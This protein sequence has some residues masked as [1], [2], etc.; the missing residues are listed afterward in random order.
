MAQSGTNYP[1]GQTAG[2]RATTAAQNEQMR[3]PPPIVSPQTV[4]TVVAGTTAVRGLGNASKLSSQEMFQLYANTNDFIVQLSS[5][6]SPM[7][8]FIQQ[9]AQISQLPMQ[10][11]R[12]WKQF[13]AA[14]S[15]SLGLVRRTGDA[16]LDAAAAQAASATAAIASVNAQA[17]ANVRAAETEIAL[18]TAQQQAAV[19]ANEQA[20]ASARLTAANE[21]LT[22]ANSQAAVS[23]RA[24]ATAQG[25]SS[26]ASNAATAA[27]TRNLTAM[28]RAGLVGIA[29]LAASAVAFGALTREANQGQNGLRRFTTEMGYTAKEVEELNS[30]SV[31]FGDTAKAVFVVGIERVASFFGFK[32]EDIASAWSRALNWMASTTRAVMAGI[33][34]AVAGMAYG[35]NNIVDNLGD[36]KSNDNPFANMVTGY[37]EAYG[38]AQAFFDDVV[39]SAQGAA[40]ARQD[41]MAS[42]MKS[43]GSKGK[44]GGRSGFDRAAE[45]AKANEELDTQIK[46]LAFYGDELERNQ[47]LEQI[48]QTFRQ[49]GAALSGAETKIIADKIQ[50]LQ[51]GRRVQEAMTAAEEAANGPAR[52]LMATEE[53]LVKLLAAGAI[54]TANYTAQ[55]NLATQAFDDAVDPLAALNRELKLSGELMGLYGRDRDVA[56]FIQSLEQ[57][58]QAKGESI[59]EQGTGTPGEGI[60]VVGRGRKMNSDAQSAVDEYKRQQ[61]QQEMTQA[62][63]AIDPQENQRPGDDSYILDRHRE[64]YAAIE[65]FRQEDVRNEEAATRRKQNLDNALTEARLS[66][67][68]GM[69]GQLATLQNSHIREVAAIGKAAAIAQATIDGITAVQAALRGP[70]GPPWSFAIAATTAVMTAANVAKIAGV[71]FQAGGYTGMGADNEVAG[72][73]HRNEYVMN[74]QATRRIGI[75]ALEAMASGGLGAGGPPGSLPPGAGQPLISIG[76]ISVRVEGKSD[77]PERT[78][79]EVQAG[80]ERAMRGI[81]R[82]EIKSQQRDG[83]LLDNASMSQ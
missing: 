20:L 43:P 12:S 44:G 65:E 78:G 71:G 23:T 15:E 52:T 39:S 5:G 82:T 58:A 79:R 53:A 10:M 28:G 67:A 22:G 21:A 70:P 26:D 24:L 59:Y 80:I 75:P 4:A 31:G 76:Q 40:R 18:A 42:E 50:K 47:Q 63:E 72:A 19:T 33:Y 9:G 34:A 35:V 66:T 51:D 81:A 56:S 55:M 2:S 6:Q 77:D 17:V 32:T 74:A 54:S 41:G 64:M 38:D 61:R 69:F 14:I 49:N 29:V 62:F 48:S 3:P 57:A 30:V 16:M 1:F 7:T 68:S 73:V 13:G 11:G 46:L 60:G 37:K 27:S 8:A 36:G 83:G 25:R 45:W